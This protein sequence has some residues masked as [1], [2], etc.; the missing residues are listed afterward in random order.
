MK[1]FDDLNITSVNHFNCHPYAERFQETSLDRWVFATA[2]NN[3]ATMLNLDEFLEQVKQEE[4][5]G[6]SKLDEPLVRVD[7]SASDIALATSPNSAY[8]FDP[9]NVRFNEE[10]L[11]PQ[12][13]QPKSRKQFV[14]DTLK[15]G[16]YWARRAK[17]NVAAKRS[18]EARRLK[19]NQIFLRANYLEKENAALK[20]TIEKLIHEHNRLQE[21]LGQTPQQMK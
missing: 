13:I 14:P 1:N 7:F 4:I 17:N 8:Q 5:K 20:E 2:H 10:E 6:R 3:P 9:S 19:E 16:R 18:R 15:D 21:M 11:K 12:P